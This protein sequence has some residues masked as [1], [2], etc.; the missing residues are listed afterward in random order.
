MFIF[1]MLI[2]FRLVVQLMHLSRSILIGLTLHMHP[3]IES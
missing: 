2:I 1:Q 3:Q